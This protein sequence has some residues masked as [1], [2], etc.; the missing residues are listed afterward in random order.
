MPLP[1]IGQRHFC[2]AGHFLRMTMSI[3][4]KEIRAEPDFDE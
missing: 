3:L 1:Q 4:R 2:L